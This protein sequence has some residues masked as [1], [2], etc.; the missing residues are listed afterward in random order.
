MDPL[1]GR[2]DLVGH[3]AAEGL[4]LREDGV[5][6]VRGRRRACGEADGLGV[7]AEFASRLG[8]EGVHLLGVLEQLGPTLGGWITD[9]YTWRWIFFI[10][11][12][13][14]LLAAFMCIVAL[15]DPEH[16]KARRAPR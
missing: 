12:P 15:V 2:H 7:A 4:E 16:M 5:D 10:N 11:L 9:H 1:A 13:L 6:Q 8:E 3:L 14:G